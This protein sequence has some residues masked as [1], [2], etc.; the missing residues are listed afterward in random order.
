MVYFTYTFLSGFDNGDETCAFCG[1]ISK[2]MGQ[3]IER[4]TAKL[5]QESFQ[6]LSN[7]GNDI[8]SLEKIENLIVNI[9]NHYQLEV[10]EEH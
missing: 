2:T 6:V 4:C 3:H 1:K 5:T 9:K 10:P 8:F 7:H